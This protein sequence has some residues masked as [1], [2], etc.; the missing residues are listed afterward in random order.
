MLVSPNRLSN[1]A[2]S[3][4]HT[5]NR[6]TALAL[7]KRA[8]SLDPKSPATRVNL[9]IAYTSFGRYAE[10]SE[11]LHGLVTENPADVAAWHAYGVLSLVS[12]QPAD[13]VSCFERCVQLNPAAGNFKFDHALA[14]MQNDQWAA[15][16]EAYEC[17]RD[18]KPERVFTDLPRWDGTP[19]QA[20][21]VWAEQG[22][23]DTFQFARYLPL[24]AAQ[25]KRTILAVP[26]SLWCL[27]EGYK[28]CGV[29]LLK[30]GTVAT[31]VDAEVSLMSLPHLFGATPAE[32]PADPGLLGKNISPRYWSSTPTRL[33]VGLCWAVNPS[34]HHSLERT[35]PFHSL[36]QLTANGDI[37]FESL[38]VGPASADIARSQAQTVVVDLSGQLTDDWASTASAIKALDVVVTTDT[39]VAHLAAILKK[40]TIMLLARRD[41]WRW[42]NMGDKTRWYPT[43]TIIRQ[44][45][46]F[47][48][49]REVQQVSA[50]LGQA[51]R[52]RCANLAA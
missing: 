9:A 49:D 38:Q 50:L 39:S 46:P 13:A 16:W 17:R 35:V 4:L 36:L 37:D 25:S 43:M 3:L 2:A 31:D 33:A 18:H 20:V 29:E 12:A 30:L 41:W 27:F 5:T 32:W 40:P 11:L 1:H 52:E 24:V 47:S 14:L 8:V 6:Q 44:Q 26:P 34:S 42:G 21:Y 23:G 28:E 19:D 45:T 48:W 7:F 51:A 15:G 22:I 10:A